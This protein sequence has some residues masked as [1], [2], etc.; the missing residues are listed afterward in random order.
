MGHEYPIDRLI[1]FSLSFCCAPWDR[2]SYKPGKELTRLLK[3]DAEL[4]ATIAAV[5]GGAVP[6]APLGAHY[7]Q[8]VWAMATGLWCGC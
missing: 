4:H 5:A 8:I 3:Q 6:L 7:E 2:A 1:V